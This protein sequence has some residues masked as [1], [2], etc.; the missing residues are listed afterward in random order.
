[1]NYNEAAYLHQ[2]LASVRHGLSVDESDSIFDAYNELE[3][4]PLEMTPGNTDIKGHEAGAFLL[5]KGVARELEGPYQ[6][7][8]PDPA[9]EAPPSDGCIKR[10]HET[11]ETALEPNPLTAQLD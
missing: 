1:M 11:E 7:E 8:Q 6:G 9:G 4:S 3:A 2:L 10:A 5:A